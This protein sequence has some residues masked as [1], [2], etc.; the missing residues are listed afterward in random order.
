[1]KKL[2]SMAVAMAAMGASPLAAL[3][4]G[5][6][7]Y[8]D[9]QYHIPL[10][11]FD[12]AW[13]TTQGSPE[14]KIAV[15][16]TGVDLNHREFANTKFD[17]LSYNGE[18][19][20]VGIQHLMDDDGHGTNV[21]GVI[22]A[23]NMDGEGVS[24]VAPGVTIMVI[25]ANKSSTKTYNP[26]RVAVGIR[27]AADNG[28]HIVNLSVAAT[29]N[30]QAISDAIN[31]AASKDVLVVAAAGNNKTSASYYPAA[32]EN[33]I[34]VSSVDEQSNFSTFSNYG[35]H[36]DVAAAGTRIN[37]TRYSSHNP[38]LSP[39][40]TL[41]GTSYA[42]P[43]VSAALAMIKSVNPEMTG[44]QLKDRLLST[45]RDIGEPGV[46]SRFGHGLIDVHAALTLGNDQPAGP[47]SEPEPISHESS[48]SETTTSETSAPVSETTS[49][50][51]SSETPSSSETTSSAPESSEEQ[52]S[53]NLSS[54]TPP[55]TSSE[56]TTSSEPETTSE[57]TTEETTTSSEPETTSET[58]T[59]ETTT[60]SEPET[61]SETTTEET[62]TSSE[63]ISPQPEEIR[64]WTVTFKV[65]KSVYRLEVV[66]D[67]QTVQVPPSPSV[68][69]T[70]LRS[71]M[72]IVFSGWVTESG[73][74]FDFSSPITSDTVIM[75][76]FRMAKIIIR[77]AINKK[78]DPGRSSFFFVRGTSST[79]PAG[80]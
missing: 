4:D 43:Q 8:P 64:T 31:Y 74:A 57:T 65:V 18:D 54:L 27:Y 21:I 14:V 17:P 70:R 39:Y 5:V 37:M 15:I 10:S 24:G 51:T 63:P 35:E 68:R 77:S 66:E 11:G 30:D 33:V 19:D 80:A 78:E 25:K 61:T 76:R 69:F 2:L 41:N 75:A 49:E 71:R 44:Q 9:K 38:A 60:S 20:S 52:T 42:A 23:D 28:A 7:S 1:M 34:A 47:S 36:I 26:V 67:G 56:T 12:R 6:P 16:D 62:T 13:Q 29:V 55:T 59:E 32:L 45:A 72:V 48:F 53:S 79:P 50:D 73:Q 3:A 22:S 40:S 58:T 46:D